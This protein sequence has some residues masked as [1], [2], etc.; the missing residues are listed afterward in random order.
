MVTEINAVNEL[1]VSGEAALYEA[2]A[3]VAFLRGADRA[4]WRRLDLR[5]FVGHG[6]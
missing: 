4:D 5:P 2:G 3:A 1:D 6:G